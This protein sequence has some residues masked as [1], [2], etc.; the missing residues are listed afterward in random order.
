MRIKNSEDHDAWDGFGD[1]VKLPQQTNL[2]IALLEMDNAVA[3]DPSKQYACIFIVREPAKDSPVHMET[4]TTDNITELKRQFAEKHNVDVDQIKIAKSPYD[5]TP[6]DWSLIRFDDLPRIV[7]YKV[8][9]VDESFNEPGYTGDSIEECF[10]HI[11]TDWTEGHYYLK[12]V[13]YYNGNE[14]AANI[15]ARDREDRIYRVA[16]RVKTPSYS[17]QLVLYSE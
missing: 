3:S 2:G 9:S 8:W 13:A 6:P 12:E 7:R 10:E 11:S 14:V 1:R 5:V 15:I 4:V 16:Y 17:K